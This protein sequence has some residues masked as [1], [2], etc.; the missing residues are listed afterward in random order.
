MQYTPL[1]DTASTAGSMIN[2][3]QIENTRP[4]KLDRIDHFCR[5]CRAKLVKKQQTD[6]T[7]TECLSQRCESLEDEVTRLKDH[8]IKSRLQVKE[9]ESKII[10][11]EA[12]IK[13]LT[14][15]KQELATP[16]S[17]GSGIKVRGQLKKSNSEDLPI[18]YDHIL[19]PKI[20]NSR[21]R[22]GLFGSLGASSQ[23]N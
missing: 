12:A 3:D 15:P 7:P 14:A 16:Y 10:A 6:H 4:I 19:Q 1:L 13:G 8:D 5:P 18:N 17:F 11:L 20:S 2:V 21:E 23:K 9:L 22:V